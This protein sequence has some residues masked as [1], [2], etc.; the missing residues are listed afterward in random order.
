MKR[1]L[2]TRHYGSIQLLQIAVI[3]LMSLSSIGI[4]GVGFVVKQGLSVR[5]HQAKIIKDTSRYRE[6]RYQLWLNQNQVKHFPDRIP[7]DASNVNLAFSR[8][9]LQGSNFFQIKF[10]LPEQ[11]IK[12]LLTQYRTV[13]KHLY[14]GGNTNEHANLPNGVPTTFFYTSGSQEDSFPSSYEIFVLGA[15]DRGNTEFKWNHGDSYGVAIDSSA[16][17]I[18]YWAEEW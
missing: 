15:N 13:A 2:P 6:I 17:E 5:N 3:V 16:S 14:R 12:R 7:A 4:V 11:Q 1:S 8:G 18:V 9:F 10:K